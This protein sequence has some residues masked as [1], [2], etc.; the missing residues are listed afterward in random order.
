MPTWRG[1]ALDA[2][3]DETPVIVLS[4]GLPER[5]RDA[6]LH[7]VAEWSARA[8]RKPIDEVVRWLP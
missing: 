4:F 6:E 1:R 3:D 5:P 7:T 8:N 2:A